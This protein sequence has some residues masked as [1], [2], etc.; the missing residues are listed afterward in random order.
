MATYRSTTFWLVSLLVISAEV[1]SFL[2]LSSSTRTT[3]R[4]ARPSSRWMLDTPTPVSTAANVPEAPT[5]ENHGAIS[6]DLEELA[7][8]L[9]G[10]GR[11]QLC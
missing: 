5:D 3:T 8:H 11:A 4:K 1:F 10:I 9:G 6:M 2:S 7:N